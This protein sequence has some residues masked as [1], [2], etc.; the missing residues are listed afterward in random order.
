MTEG[1]STKRETYKIVVY[2]KENN[3]DK[4]CNCSLVVVGVFCGQ[5]SAHI[6][7]LFSAHTPNTNT[8]IRIP[9]ITLR[10]L[11]TGFCL[12]VMST[13]THFK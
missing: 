7:T 4:V 12:T 5:Q 1:T 2:D 3:F 9:L 11:I 6:R 8:K 13:M 10:W